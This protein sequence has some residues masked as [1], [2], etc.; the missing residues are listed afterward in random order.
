MAVVGLVSVSLAICAFGL[1]RA[2]R[3]FGHHPGQR[4]AVDGADDVTVQ[5]TA[6]E[7]SPVDVPADVPVYPVERPAETRHDLPVFVDP[8]ETHE[9]PVIDESHCRRH[10]TEPCTCGDESWVRPLEPYVPTEPNQIVSVDD[11]TGP[12]VWETNPEG[13]IGDDGDEIPRVCPSLCDD[14]CDAD[15]HEDH[16]VITHREPDHRHFYEEDEDPAELQR[17]FDALPKI[18]TAQPN[19]DDATGPWRTP[20]ATPEE[21]EMFWEGPVG[22]E[23]NDWVEKLRTSSNGRATRRLKGLFADRGWI[24]RGQRER[25]PRNAKKRRRRRTLSEYLDVRERRRERA[26]K[27]GEPGRH[28]RAT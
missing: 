16:L 24:D 2:S 3:V 27:T 10:P 6:T 20:V 21:Y 5:F 25:T 23:Q 9:L 28:R 8:H 17:R 15:C 1:V 7:T 12:P 19:L 26:T 4:V 14:D 13:I 11:L 18:E 22:L